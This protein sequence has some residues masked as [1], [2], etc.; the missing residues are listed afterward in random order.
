DFSAGTNSVKG[1]IRAHKTPLKHNKSSG[2]D[3]NTASAFSET[4]CGSATSEYYESLKR[5]GVKYTM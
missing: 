5:Q 1:S 4:N 2:K 3:T